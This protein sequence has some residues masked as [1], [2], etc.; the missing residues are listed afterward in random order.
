MPS[1]WRNLF[2]DSTDLDSRLSELLQPLRRLLSSLATAETLAGQKRLQAELATALL[3]YQL[4]GWLVCELISEHN[5]HLYRLAIEQTLDEMLAEGWGEPPLAFCVLVMGSGGRHESLLHPDQDNALIIDSYPPQRHNEIDPWFLTLA[6]GFTRRL[7]SAGIPLCKGEVMASRPLWR[8]PINDWR[9]QMSLWMASRKV[10]LVQQCNIL[11]DF[12]PVYGDPALAQQLRDAVMEQVPTAG[13]FL[14]EMAELFDE[15][16]V[17]LDRFERLQGDGR[18]APHSDA[19]NLK[20]QGLLPLTASLRRLALQHDC[21]EVGS[22]SRLDALAA[23]GAL[24]PGEARALKAV[25]GRL[26]ER[27]LLTQLETLD[28][29]RKPDNWIDLR[30]L[31]HAEQEQLKLDLKRVR[32]LQRIAAA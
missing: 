7:D 1:I 6:E 31:S 21:R 14:H 11:F 9:A 29:G 16:P 10:K 27:L 25:F 8:K 2:A 24:K 12:S 5:D 28:Q 4:P 3:D 32:Q 23:A 22:R 13:L 17:A 15:A 20:R 30:C 18:E 19:I 26:L